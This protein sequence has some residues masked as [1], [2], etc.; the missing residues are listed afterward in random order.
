MASPFSIF[1]KNQKTMMV[2]LCVMALF[3][4]TLDSLFNRSEP[5]R[6]L[7]GMLIGAGGFV[8]VGMKRGKAIEF[9]VLGAVV[10]LLIGFASTKIGGADAVVTTIKQDFSRKELNALKERR[11]AANEFMRLANSGYS[12]GPVDDSVLLGELLRFEA[13]ELGVSVSP[14]LVTEFLKNQ[15][16]QKLTKDELSRALKQVKYLGQSPSFDVLVREILAPELRAQLALQMTVPNVSVTPEQYWNAYRKLH[17][18]A[19]ITGTPISIDSFMENAGNPTDSEIEALFEKYKT[20]FPNPFADDGPQPG[21]RQP[22][23]VELGY[24]EFAADNLLRHVKAPTDEEIREYYEANKEEKYKIQNVDLDSKPGPSFPSF[25]D[26]PPKSAPKVITPKTDATTPGAKVKTDANGDEKKPSVKTIPPAKTIPPVRTIPPVKAPLESKP[27]PKAIP[28]GKQPAKPE[29]KTSA[30]KTPAP[31]QPAP[32][33]A[34]DSKS[35]ESTDGCDEV[36]LVQNETAQPS[37]GKTDA[38]QPVTKPP[39]AKTPAV[40]PPIA[41]TPKTKTTAAQPVL[42][43]PESKAKTPNSTE[44]EPKKTAKDEPTKTIPGSS[45]LDEPK[46]KEPDVPQYQQLDD[47]L[48][49]DI[50]T[51][52]L[53]QRAEELVESHCRTVLDQLDKFSDL[54]FELQQADGK[55]SA[56]LIEKTQQAMKAMSELAIVPDDGPEKAPGEWTNEYRTTGLVSAEDFRDTINFALSGARAL[57][58]TMSDRTVHADIFGTSKPPHYMPRVVASPD[59]EFHRYIYWVVDDKASH[60][61]TLADTYKKNRESANGSDD[62]TAIFQPPI[63]VRNQV[64]RAWK[65]QKARE[66]AQKRAERLKEDIEAGLDAGLASMDEA[67]NR[68]V[69]ETRTIKVPSKTT[70]AEVHKIVGEDIILAMKEDSPIGSYLL[71]QL[72]ELPS[73]NEK[74]ETKPTPKKLE[75]FNWSKVKGRTYAS[76]GFRIT[77]PEDAEGESATLTIEFFKIQKLTDDEESIEISSPRNSGRITWLNFQHS[78]TPLSFVENAGDKFMETVFNEMKVGKIRVIPNADRTTYCVVQLNSRQTTDAEEMKKIKDEFIISNPERERPQLPEG[79]PP[80]LMA[81]FAQQ[82]MN[83]PTT[84]TLAQS[85]YRGIGPKWRKQLEDKYKVTWNKTQANE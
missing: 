2:L 6:P 74:S 23:R 5:N 4:F 36:A 63:G 28:D 58:S 27:T 20:Q 25:D 9:A 26:E 47:L 32:K 29:S 51:T 44:T 65:Q 82:F 39:V 75:A 70:I 16:V 81:R 38:K 68:S 19:E 41:K 78:I 66:L 53:R 31:K 12:F 15:I 61:P 35:D 37:P 72:G 56:E 48:M 49:G 77:V 64:I 45:K 13:D 21:F 59:D 40:K 85:E 83:R 46:A 42:K 7:L 11:Q 84:A 60:V 1:R 17:V 52:I 8:F 55:P 62:D 43:V 73:G 18:G 80:E 33:K 22:R 69:D 14:A 3:A 54:G 30:P 34:A 76:Q 71:Q 24:L 50:R 67:Q 57:G 79:I 10:G